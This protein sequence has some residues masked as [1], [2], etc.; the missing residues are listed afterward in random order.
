MR[1][2]KETRYDELFYLKIKN[3]LKKLTLFL[4]DFN[5]KYIKYT[6]IL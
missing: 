4:Y 2:K 6:V 3:N 5:L 1:N